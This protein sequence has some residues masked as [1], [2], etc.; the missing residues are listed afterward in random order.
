MIRTAG[1][2][3]A[4]QLD[5]VPIPIVTAGMVLIRVTAAGV[6]RHDVNQRIAGK[7]TDGT[8][9]PG[10]EVCGE[11]VSLGEGVTEPRL[12]D[13][14]MALVQ[15]GGYGQYVA[16]SAALALPAPT[17]LTDTEAASLPEALFTTWWNYFG[18]M[19]LEKDQYALI[20]GGTSGVGHLALQALSSLGYKPIATAGSLVKVAAALEFGALA[21][22]SYSDPDLAN[23]VMTAT[24]GQGISAL[25]DMSG[26]AHIE[27]DV[28]MMAEDGWIAHLSGGTGEFKLPLRTV[29]ARRIRLT[30]SLLRPLPLDRK[31]RIAEKL[32]HEVLPLVGTK[33]RPRIAAEFNLARAAEAHRLLEEGQ[34]IGKIVL[35][36]AD[37]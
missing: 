8:P 3:E 21:A 16:A 19:A 36:V 4:L 10:L 11:V 17:S 29:M 31:R 22:F 15:G 33:I 13:R 25:L 20:H 5:R 34:Q 23:K 14:V 2:P 26:G 28:A 32:R 7:H 35:R 6:N 18:L 30:G 24:A 9:I 12:G 37:Q 1:G 27:Q